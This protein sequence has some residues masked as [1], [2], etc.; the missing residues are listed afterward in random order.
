MFKK[1]FLLFIAVVVLMSCGSFGGTQSN[2]K[3]TEKKEQSASKKE[4]SARYVEQSMQD[5]YDAK[6]WI[7]GPHN[8]QLIIIGV[9]GRLSKPDDEI[10][11]AKQDAAQKVAMYHGIRGSYEVVNTSGPYGFF[12]FSHDSKLDLVPNNNYEQYIER[13]TFDPEKDVIRGESAMFFGDAATF[14][15]FKYSPSDSLVNYSPEGGTGR[16]SWV[17][18]VDLPQYEGYT[19]VVGFAGKRHTLRETIYKSCE[20]AAATLIST[21]PTTGDIKDVVVTGYNSSA[22]ATIKLKSEGTLSN[23]QILGHWI[24]QNGAVSTLAIARVSK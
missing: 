3:S 10:E 6:R 1:F 15:R 7:S 14:I 4:Q 8:G 23:F 11:A 13:L 16:P 20:S 21:A 17:N 19:T 22:L 12:D 18:S 9:S 5:Q 2:E 24:D